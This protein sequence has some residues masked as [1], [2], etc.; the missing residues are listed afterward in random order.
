MCALLYDSKESKR[1]RRGLPVRM[2]IASKYRAGGGCERAWR[3]F[4]SKKKFG[5]VFSGKTFCIGAFSCLGSLV[6]WTV[7]AERRVVTRGRLGAL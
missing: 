7:F 4:K 1:V 5:F 3:G 6:V 2:N